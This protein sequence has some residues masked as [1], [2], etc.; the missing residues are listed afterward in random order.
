MTTHSTPPQT[1][2][3]THIRITGAREHNLKG[4][5]VEIG[6]GLTV[7]T[8]VSGS[9]KTSLVFDTLYHEARRRFLE[10]FNVG[11]GLRLA[12]AHVESLTGVGPAVAVE[13]NLLNRNPSSTLATASGLHPFLRLLYARFGE[14]R[15]AHCGASLTVMTEDEIVAQVTALSEHRPL[16]L[17]APLLRGV[18]GSHRTL[19]HLL[20]DEFDLDALRVDGQPWNGQPLDPTTPHTMEVEIARWAEP[21]T[22]IQ[23][24]EAVQRAWALGVDALGTES[25][26]FC[27]EAFCLAASGRAVSRRMLARAPVCAECGTWFSALEPAHFHTPCPHC[28]GEGCAICDNTGLHPEAAATRWDG[29]RLPDLLA[30]PVEDARALF[31]EADLP[32]SAERLQ[33]EIVRRLEALDRVG[34]GYLSL[35]RPAPTLSRG[36]SQR[37]RLAVILTSR[38]EDM[39]HV[40]D[41]PTVGQ[42]PADVAR[43]LSAFRDLPGPV[44]FVE[45]DRVAAAAADHAIDLGPG[46]GN[47]GGE[48]VF[49]GTPAEL[50]QTDTHTGRYFS[51]RERV[52]V[53]KVRPAPEQFLWLQGAHMRNLQAID[54]PIALGRLNVITGVSGSGKSTLVEE[55]L[56]PSL[57]EGKA[58]GCRGITLV[59]T[60]DTEKENKNSVLSVSSEAKTPK[61]V[62]VDQSPIGRNPRSN[63]ATYTKL[64][65][66]I[67]DFWA[68][69]TGLSP[70][71]FS[72]NR[73]E[74]ACPTCKGLGA[75]EVRMRYL[76][77]TWIPCTDCDGQRFSDEVLDAKVQFGERRLSIADLY[78]LGTGEV[79]RLLLRDPRLTGRQRRAARHILS[80][81]RDIGLGYLHLGQ[82]SPTLSGGEAQRVK[83]AKFLGK[84]NLSDSVL[85]LDEPSTGLHPKDIAGLLTVLDRLVRSGA[86][87]VIVEHNTDVIRAADWVIDLGPG[88]GP[89]GGRLLY[90]GSPDGLLEADGSLTGKALR[91]ETVSNQPSAFSDQLSAVSSQP[92]GVG[93]TGTICIRGAWANNLKGIDVDIPKGKLTVVTGVSGSGKSSLVGDV[94]EAEARRRL[95]ESL[96]MYERQGMRE[97]PEAPVDAVSG[98][99]VVVTVGSTRGLHARRA[100]V[101]TVTELS[102]HLAILLSWIGERRCLDCG[103]MMERHKD[104][105]HCP[106]C[107]QTAPVAP[108]RYFQPTHYAAACTICNGVGTLRKPNPDKLVIRPDLPLCA[109]AMHSPGFFPKGYLCK[110]FNGGYYQVQA[111]ATKYG[112]DPATTP[113]N[114]M[115]PEAQHVFLFGDPEPMLVH[116][117]SKNG[118]TRDYT[119]TFPG[120][121]GWIGDWD[122]GGTYTDTELCP[123]CAGGKLRPE[124]LAVTLGGHN[125]HDLSTMPLSALYD[126]LRA[127]PADTLGGAEDMPQWIEP[128]LKICLQ[129]L[130][131]L[132]RVGVGYMH[133]DRP[134]STVSAGE[135]QRL[136]L[137]GLLGSGLTSLTVLLDEPT[138]GLHPSEV[139]ALV[140]ALH[141]LRGDEE[142]GPANGGASNT[143]IVVEHDPE[144]L[145]AADYLIDVGPGAGAAGG[146]IVAQGVPE[147]VAQQATT[148]ARWLRGER[149]PLL[150]PRHTPDGWMHIHGAR[151]NNLK[152][153]DVALPLGTLVGLCGVSGSGKSTLLIDTLGLA[154]APKKQ[155]TSVA[156]ENVEPGAHTAI[157]NTPKRVIVV[158]QT[159]RGIYSPA[160]FLGLNN[161]IHAFYAEGEDAQAL[162][163]DAKALGERC[164]VC[165]GSGTTR[166]EMGFLPDMFELCEVCH[167]TGYRAEAWDVRLRGVALPDLFGLTID[168]VCELFGDVDRLALPLMMAREVGLGYLTLRQPGYALSGGEAQ[169]L[170]IAKEL[171]RKTKKGEPTLYILDEP[172]LGLHLED[173][174]QLVRVL[175]RL[176]EGEN[177]VPNTVLVVEHHPHVLAACDWLVELGPVGGPEGGYVI[178]EGTPEQVAAGET[179][180]ACYI[181]E[182]LDEASLSDFHH[183]SSRILTNREKN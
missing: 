175:H 115:S 71:H 163:L 52:R 99:G 142:N 122:I 132:L 77:S 171:C 107:G 139:R 76:P 82:P 114:E 172:T 1:R 59:T 116:Y 155:T 183:E 28:Q 12:P 19:L 144:V 79:A 113:W 53:P 126:V 73:P 168:Q 104:E 32:V 24:R 129:R 5:D 25:E 148:T 136:S 49:T 8:G 109:G 61:P 47:K 9:G 54:V 21:V 169:R 156:Y 42:H 48:V 140:D 167:G 94:L 95:L 152:D 39:L 34:L 111:A 75:V 85:I 67:R 119:G 63:P 14:R 162:G 159:K 72:F 57:A 127:L 128:S 26:A 45:H 110:P 68:E 70:S 105:W 179:P 103:R 157:E 117:E 181:R 87:I 36:E 177:G 35:D 138:R 121:F 165:G 174:A 151:G 102:H 149:Q 96:S 146:E 10:V 64:A 83:L 37:A 40:L 91:E 141:E 29:L 56:T 125:M 112:F 108:P 17:F 2:T 3:R 166:I 100:T 50:W 22:P 118:R 153:I 23:A 38:L 86:T 160:N 20:T 158:D 106:H 170:K 143:V 84:R 33:T 97:G 182:I 62:M 74:G 66:T 154:L 180:T 55:V 173:V 137:A 150:L 44:V 89:K 60:E 69:Q 120:F 46:A 134:A 31:A 133:L 7:V 6:D 178:A 124:Y 130:R 101:G 93:G 15:C 123:G 81:L 43:L 51:L 18:R 65:D 98:L 4:V 176:V 30:L 147:A 58:A 41:E 90:A 80:A 13:Q 88:A 161:V 131:F 78:E 92:S 164:S 16:A 27:R 11:G 135:A 145:R